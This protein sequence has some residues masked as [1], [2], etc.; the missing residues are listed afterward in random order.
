MYEQKITTTMQALYQTLTQRKRPEDVA[1]MILEELAGNLTRQEVRILEKAAQGSLK[2]RFLKYTSMAQV[3]AQPVGAQKQVAKTV[4]LFK[5]E[6]SPSVDANDPAAVEA[7]IREVA[8]IIHKTVGANHYLRDRLNKSQRE[9]GGLDLSKRQYNKLFRQLRFLEKKLGKMVNEAHK[10]EYQ[11][12]SKHGLAHRISFEEFIKDRFSACF[13][14]YYTARCNLRSEFTI[15]GQQRPYDEIADMLF[16]KATGQRMF[17]DRLLGK[18]VTDPSQPNYLAIAYV[19]P[20]PVVL[21]ELTDAQ[22]GELLGQWTSIL[23]ELAQ[24]LGKIWKENTINR[25][26]MIVKRGND[27]S[28]WNA[29][30]GAWNKS[31]DAWINLVY[32]MGL[33]FV[34][35]E[36][37]FGKALRLMAADVVA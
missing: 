5:L 4:E 31:R 34:L 26:T 14:A 36:L 15:A 30:A 20:A 18:P 35:D 2:K 24:F 33:E 28:T 7:F 23:Q 22:K 16:R 19:Y 13:I 29:M 8:P 3:F 9:S 32:A 21:A 11:Q 6:Q 17:L 25:E 10:S 12:V 37:C 1:E 27:S